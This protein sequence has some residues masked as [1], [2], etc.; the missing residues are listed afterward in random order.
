LMALVFN[1]LDSSLR[2]VVV[3]VIWSSMMESNV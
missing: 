2:L 1:V 3:G